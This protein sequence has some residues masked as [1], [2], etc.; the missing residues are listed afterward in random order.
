MNSKNPLVS[1]VIPAYN[2]ERYIKETID[3]AIA[4]T[5]QHIEIIVVDN[6]SKDRTKEILEPYVAEGKVRY[7]YNETNRGAAGARNVGIHEAKGEYIALLDSDDIFLPEKVERQV[8][9]LEAHP[10]CD[11]CYCALY[12]FYDGKPEKLLKLDYSYYSGDSVFPMLFQKNFINPGT[13]MLRRSVFE[14]AGYFDESYRHSEDFEFFLRI[15]FQ[16]YR[17]NFLSEPLLKCRL[18]KGSTSYSAQAKVREKKTMGSIFENIRRQ[19]TDEQK[20]QVHINKVIFINR[21]K[22]IY[23]E[24]AVRFPPFIMFHRWIQRK[25]L[26]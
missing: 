4:Q 9:Y 12:H 8:A 11:V 7:L 16:G 17:V 23:A 5:Y 20:R 26:E 10:E 25:H 1:I 6:A 21:M 3:S 18:H 15:A 19:M 14:K 24:I 2:S 13:T 22:L